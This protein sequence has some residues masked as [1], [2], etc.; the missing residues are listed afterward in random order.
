MEMEECLVDVE[1][2]PAQISVGVGSTE[3]SE[4]EPK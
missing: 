3:S 1:G 4:E 2:R